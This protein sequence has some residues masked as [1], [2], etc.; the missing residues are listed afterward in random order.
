MGRMADAYSVKILLV[1]GDEKLADSIAGH[2]ENYFQKRSVPVSCD[3]VSSVERSLLQLKYYEYDIAVVGMR[4]APD[5][6]GI[7]FLELIRQRK[8]D[9]PVIL[10]GSEEDRQAAEDAYNLGAI[11]FIPAREESLSSIPEVADNGMLR[12]RATREQARLN[13][14]LMEKNIEMRAVN[15]LLARQ[16]VRLLKLRKDQES[17]RQRMESL[18]N[19]M[20]D[21]VVFVNSQREIEM[22]NPAARLIFRLPAGGA[23]TFQDLVAFI[24]S[25]PFEVGLSTDTLATIFS[26]EY[27]ISACA[28][29]FEGAQ[30]G[31]MLVLHDVTKEMELERMKAEFQSMVS[32]ELR[33]PL[34]AIRGAVENF[35][36]GTLGETTE[37]QKVFLQ[38]MMRNA[39]RLTMLVNDMLDLSKL[40]AKM[41]SLK[42]EQVDP[43][44]IV[45]LTHE[46]FRY[47]C[48]EKGVEISMEFDAGMPHI[49]ADERML[50]QILDNL[51]SNALK[52]TP[53]GG[54]IILEA[55]N[56]KGVAEKTVQFRV[57]DSGIGVPDHLKEKIF[58]RYFQADSGVQR[59]YKGTGLGLAICRKMAEL[60]NATISCEDA[61][62]GGSMFVLA[63]PVE[64]AVRHKILLVST[65]VEASRL[66]EEI[67]GREF[68]LVRPD[69]P[70]TAGKKVAETLPELILMDYHMPPMD[71]IGL[72]SDMRCV[73]ATVRIPVIFL[74]DGITE[75]ERAKALEMG[76]A[77]II[78][79][80]YNPGEF[81]A[82]V[83]RVITLSL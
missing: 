34:T 72:F 23:L 81:L 43:S 80:P 68:C 56:G 79:R 29:E 10:V 1:D 12:Y 62:S 82:R 67:L 35:Q 25:S 7:D 26:S 20:S 58:D 22:L 32:H 24:G 5:E 31:R 30:M 19:A 48:K 2:I 53:K 55:R 59:Q 11:A 41:M 61:P 46:S 73:P 4:P 47:A 75:Q 37:Q 15:E 63:V 60:H 54:R 83:K 76:A 18:L 8:Y 6:Y 42:P 38:M 51:A 65:N 70:Q 17:Q 28:V 14:D 50:A 44:Y 71:V 40:E 78:S 49:H 66:D 52:F 77:D 69:T 33:T 64:M 9:F 74:G 39:E 57:S 27:E 3:W 36:R 21:G 16:S 45:R 13:R